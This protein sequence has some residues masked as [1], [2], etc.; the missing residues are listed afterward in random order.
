MVI[1]DFDV[2]FLLE[3]L[4]REGLLYFPDFFLKIILVYLAGEV[5][6]G[7]EP[8]FEM[9]FSHVRDLILILK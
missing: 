6:I 3:V 7:L 8:H 4:F 2:I 1:F 9:R 5:G